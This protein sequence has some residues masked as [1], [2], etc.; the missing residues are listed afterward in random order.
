M[1]KH[2]N[3]VREEDCWQA[4]MDVNQTGERGFENTPQRKKYTQR[5]SDFKGVHG[6]PTETLQEHLHYTS[7]QPV[8]ISLDDRQSLTAALKLT[9]WNDIL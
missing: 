4:S 7:V 6:V 3:L 2:K 5:V 1:F 9:V 8:T